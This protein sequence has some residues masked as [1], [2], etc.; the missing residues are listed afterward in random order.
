M[1]E[2][3]ALARFAGKTALVTGGASGLGLASAR[4]LLRE[5]ARVA[6][7][8]INA[9]ALRN[10]VKELAQPPGHVSQHMLDVTDAAQVEAVVQ[11]AWQTHGAIDVLVNSAGISYQGSV[12]DTPIEAWRRVL[13][14]NLSG[15]YLCTQA[16]ARRMVQRRQGRIVMIASI[17][18]Q[19]VWSGRAAYCA[20]KGGVLALAKSCA[21]DL[22]PFGIT[23][24][25][26][27]P[28]PIETAQTAALHG[29]V[30]RQAIVHATPMAR[31]GQADEVADA[32]AFLAS[33]DA[34]FVNGHDLVVDGGLTSAAILYDL[35][36]NPQA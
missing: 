30:I 15:S 16:V 31:Y 14:I 10:V 2:P 35:K 17:S 21:I 25:S 18:G 27:S 34:R 7:A 36:Q 29:P 24:N 32:I 8:D 1:S 9:H 5:G 28:G 4:R 26:V 20:S 33:D 3:I 12:L 13:D 11:E 6:L 22:A 19:Q 23:V